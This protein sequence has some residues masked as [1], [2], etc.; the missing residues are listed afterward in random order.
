MQELSANLKQ[1]YLTTFVQNHT[2]L[3]E[4]YEKESKSHIE[5]LSALASNEVEHRHHKRIERLLK[6]AKLPRAKTLESFDYTR[7]PGLSASLLKRLSQGEFIDCCENILVFGNPG[8]GKTHLAIALAQEWC[9]QGRR[10]YFST[11]AQLIQELLKAKAELRLNTLLKKF[12]KIEMLI[13]DDISYTACDREEA[14]VLFALLASRYEMRS[15]MVTSNLPFGKW[16][17]IFKDEMTTTAAVDRLVHHASI[18]ELNAESY[19]IKTANKKRRG[20]KS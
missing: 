6:Q 17:T 5:Y 10:V 18:L 4:R 9:L 7:I 15:T 20:N 16:N 2:E 13:I 12:G 3:A 1:L 19:R 8:T 11:A 14:D